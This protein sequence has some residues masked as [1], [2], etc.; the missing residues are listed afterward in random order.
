MC[1]SLSYKRRVVRFVF[2]YRVRSLRNRPCEMRRLNHLAN[3]QCR[4]DALACG[5]VAPRIEEYCDAQCVKSC[6]AAIELIRHRFSSRERSG[7][8]EFSA[9][10][11]R[12]RRGARHRHRIDARCRRMDAHFATR[13]L[14]VAAVRDRIAMAL[15]KRCP[16]LAHQFCCHKAAVEV[17]CRLSGTTKDRIAQGISHRFG[18]ARIGSFSIHVPSSMCRG[19]RS[20]S[21]LLD[22]RRLTC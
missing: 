16:H 5:R 13:D 12:M 8:W 1:D 6:G 11:L 22:A 14:R 3:Q 19:G 9:H 20:K 18:R 15:A 7:S 21:H 17:R 10:H 2:P 4:L